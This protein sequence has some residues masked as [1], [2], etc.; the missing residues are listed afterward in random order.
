MKQITLFFFILLPFLGITQQD[1]SVFYTGRG[2]LKLSNGKFTITRPNGNLIA[3]FPNYLLKKQ[4]DSLINNYNDTT[5]KSGISCVD[6]LWKVG[7][8]V[9]HRNWN[10]DVQS[11]VIDPPAV[12]GCS[13]GRVYHKNILADTSFLTPSPVCGDILVI[14]GDTCKDL[15]YIKGNS[16]SKW[17][18]IG[19]YLKNVNCAVGQLHYNVGDGLGKS[20]K[21]SG[22]QDPD[23]ARFRSIKGAGAI[24][25]KTVG[26]NIIVADSLGNL[27]IFENVGNGAFVIK[28]TINKIIKIRSVKGLGCIKAVVNND[29]IEVQDTCVAAS[30]YKFTNV[31]GKAEVLKDTL[32]RLIK[33]RTIEGLNGIKV[34][35]NTNTISIE[36]TTSLPSDYRFKNYGTGVPVLKDTLNRIIKYYA[37]KGT[38]NI[39]ATLVGD[40]IIIQDSYID[41]LQK[42]NTLIS[43]TSTFK[44]ELNKDK[45][46]NIE[47]KAGDGIRFDNNQVG[48]IG[49]VR[50]NVDTNSIAFK[51]NN[52]A[53]ANVGAGVDI[54]KNTTGF[55]P[56]TFN[57][58]RLRSSDN[59]VLTTQNADDI[60]LRA[61]VNNRDSMMNTASNYQIDTRHYAKGVL[62]G[63]T[64]LTA[65][66]N[67]EFSSPFSGE[68]GGLVIN[69]IDNGACTPLQQGIF[70]GKYVYYDDVTK[71][72]KYFNCGTT[73]CDQ[74][75]PA[76]PLIMGFETDETDIPLNSQFLTFDNS[77]NKWVSSN[78]ANQPTGTYVSGGT[79]L[80][81]VGSGAIPPNWVGEEFNIP[82][83]Y[84]P[85]TSALD[86]GFH[87]ININGV[88]YSTGSGVT[89]PI[90]GTDDATI[91]NFINSALIAGGYAANDLIWVS[92][93]DNTVTIWRNPSYTY[94]LNDFWMGDMTPNNYTNKYYP[95]TPTTHAPP[96]G[97]LA[98]YT[99]PTEKR[100]QNFHGGGATI[101][102]SVGGSAA[103][104]FVNLTAGDLTLEKS[105]IDVYINGLKHSYTAS[106]SPSTYL[107]YTVSGSQITAYSGASTIGINQIE[108]IIKP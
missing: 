51:K 29:V 11:L 26:D 106:P 20:V 30:D 94:N 83:D 16:P 93:S 19:N 4:V 38:G 95:P 28:D 54:Y 33:Y 7:N 73:P 68:Q 23:N 85:A 8:I 44:V 57:L 9:Y 49:I 65:G 42:L 10:C 75:P 99:I 100:Y 63:R 2:N 14:E 13:G 43:N 96:T 21:L 5:D 52:Y 3:V 78:I 61:D 107:S 74:P 15:L 55:D 79:Q 105:K 84:S 102:L 80:L 18:L 40:D 98:L 66:N 87:A 27:Y 91:Q 104:G 24:S 46:T 86:L 89:A 101:D 67:I 56:K 36:D 70:S 81:G 62:I 77:I 59:T 50:I 47:I 1:S 48:D 92:N 12:D 69:A 58:R 88:V 72:L 76:P 71:C 103:N 35:Q 45:S 53:V 97:G 32:N 25:V 41:T 17:N 22:V 6:S 31:G 64:T 60:D 82:S 39:T 108:V 37:I 34:T 90:I